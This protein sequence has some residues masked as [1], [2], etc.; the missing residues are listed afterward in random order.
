MVGIGKNP[1]RSMEGA[2]VCHMVIAVR[3]RKMT[4]KKIAVGSV[5]YIHSKV[6]V[7]SLYTRPRAKPLAM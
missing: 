2:M 4:M 1:R 5:Q 3:I 7:F 6:I